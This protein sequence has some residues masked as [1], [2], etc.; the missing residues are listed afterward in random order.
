MSLVTDHVLDPKQVQKLNRFCFWNA[1]EPIY[2]FYGY[3]C[4]N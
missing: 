3:L 4:D 1:I 2:Q